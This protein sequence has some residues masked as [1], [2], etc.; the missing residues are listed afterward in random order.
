MTR[1]RSIYKL[2]LHYPPTSQA[3]FAIVMWPVLFALACWQ[4]PHPTEFLASLGLEIR[5]WQIFL[6][7]F[8]AYLLLLG[9]H[10]VFNRRHFKSHA[11]EIAV[12]RQLSE[13]EQNM[14]A[15]D[16]TDA[17]AYKAVNSERVRLRKRLGFLSDTDNF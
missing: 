1:F 15:A 16:L 10:R 3:L 8:G 7:G 5:M 17:R 6:A 9:K 4:G 2:L 14:V 11:V 12:H 13:V